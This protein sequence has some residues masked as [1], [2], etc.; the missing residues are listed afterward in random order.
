MLPSGKTLRLA[1]ANHTLT[2][3]IESTREPTKPL[4]S[5]IRNMC[6]V[7]ASSALRKTSSGFC[8]CCAHCT[9][10]SVD[11]VSSSI[12]SELQEPSA[13]MKAIYHSLPSV[14]RSKLGPCSTSARRK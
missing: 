10:A 14:Q 12:V 4:A 13:L 6:K 2:P 5:A 1:R 11:L 7:A 9:R 8:F 3:V